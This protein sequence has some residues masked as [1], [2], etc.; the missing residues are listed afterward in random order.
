M[1]PAAT[2]DLEKDSLLEYWRARAEQHTRDSYAGVPFSKFPEDLR[3]YEHLLWESA[4]DTVLELGTQYGA[5]ALW[6]RDRLRTLRQYRRIS[7]RPHIV[8]VDID[9]SLA[10]EHL[11]RADA[12]FS[13]EIT[14]IEGDVVDPAVVEAVRKA[15]RRNARCF[16]IEDS[17]HTYESTAASLE[18][19]AGYVEPGGF[20]VVEDGCVDV[21]AMRISND[22]PRGVLPALQAWRETPVGGEFELRRDLELYGITCHPSGF[23]QRR[24]PTAS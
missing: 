9:Q 10:R 23:L 20:L 21:D 4:P 22:W 1:P 19:F 7:R 14:L 16:V 2:V 6:F 15:I 24:R 17:A 5:S 13:R 11:A 18:H 12:R 3:V 8:S